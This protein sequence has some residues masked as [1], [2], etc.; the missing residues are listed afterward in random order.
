MVGHTHEDVD[1]MFSRI[2]S[3][4]VKV[5][6]PTLP[7]LKAAVEPSTT[8]SPEVIHLKA[9]LDYKK[10]LMQCKGLIKLITSPHV[11]KFSEVEDHIDIHYKDWP[12][13]E[14]AYRKMDVNAFVPDLR[15]LSN[16]TVNEKIEDTLAK[17]RED[18]PKWAA[19]RRLQNSELDWW[20][21]YLNGC[22]RETAETGPADPSGPKRVPVA[23]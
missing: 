7:E 19:S 17:M 1:Q 9:I 18:L 4:M 11:F 23:S 13:D 2:S 15:N 16:V 5:D 20:R 14:E 22:K 21:A 8:P 10:A 3:R 12:Q 6:A